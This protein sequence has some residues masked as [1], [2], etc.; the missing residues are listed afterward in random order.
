MF[1][2]LPVTSTCFVPLPD[3]LSPE[4]L[5]GETVSV[6]KSPTVAVNVAVS[7]PMA[8][9]SPIVTRPPTDAGVVWSTFGTTASANVGAS[10]TALTEKFC[11]TG[12]AA[13]LAGAI[14][15]PSLYATIS[16]SFPL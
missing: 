11:V 14:V 4:G 15:E 6:A 1:T 10:L 2:K 7:E 3:T 5:A 12:V 16:E 8:S 9:T 13:R